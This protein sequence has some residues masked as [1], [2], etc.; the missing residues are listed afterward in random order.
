MGVAPVFGLQF[1]RQD[2]A[3][4]P[5]ISSNMD[6]VGLI[7]PCS[8]AN[9]NVFPLNTP[10]FV[11]SNDTATLKNLYDSNG[12]TDG[13]IVDALNGINSQLADLQIAAQVVIVV[14][15]YGSASDPN[16]KL[17]QT[18][19]NIM[20]SSVAGTG[21]WAFLKAPNTLYCTPRLIAAPG[22][23]GMMANSLDTL[24]SNVVG[25]GYQA[26]TLYTI[27]FGLG[28]GETNGAN[29][30]LPQAHAIS[31]SDGSINSSDLFIDSFGAWFT[32]APTAVLPAPDGPPIV[33]TF[34]S[35]Q[36]IFSQQPGIGSTIRLNGTTVTFVTT[37]PTGNQVQ[38][39]GN[40]GTTMSNLLTFLQGSNDTQILLCSYSLINATLTITD[41]TS[42][43][44]GNGFSL[45]STVNGISVSGSTLT[46]GQN[47]ASAV[48]ATLLC[49]IAL[50]ANPVVSA[51]SGG[52]LDGLMA[53][54]VVESAGTSMIA[55]ENWRDTIA[56]PRIIPLSGGVKVLN[57][58]GVIVVM[59]YAPR[60]IGSI[61][62]RDFATGYPFHSAA[63]QPI[64]GIVGPART[65]A[66]SLTDGSTEGQ[67]LLGA[68]IGILVRG[69]IGVETAISSGGFISIA[70][71]TAATDPLWQFYNVTRGR[72]FIELSLM[73][74]L[75]A[76]LGVSNIDRQTVTSVIGSIEAFLSQLTAL[77][78][79]LGYNV[80]FQGS[81][82]SAA[83]IRLGHLT[84]SFAAEEPPVLRRI[85]VMSARYA[86][87]ID[88]LV[89]QLATEL[90][91]QG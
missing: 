64:S 5:V 37:S 7:G 19:A 44:L 17:Q 30:V 77:Q 15:A 84:V 39:A 78:Q 56:S 41:K 4:L 66:F 85:T 82:N 63:N 46:G 14:T 53:H 11:F 2:D 38:I 75:R 83:E 91:F 1:I 10:V 28:S 48:Q 21:V 34:A 16:L 55:D 80:S 51:L 43:T 68:N 23:T 71:D 35:G 18:I 12:N 49:T 8:T 88:A 90:N 89:S 72:D 81:L 52:V 47:A 73:P 32:A 62:A 67:Q 20:G 57:S 65:I 3:S 87:A 13:Y 6:V 74:A 29:V 42:G 86:P 26:N 22:Y 76:Y 79:I 70:T 60:E 50:G 54:A 36:M 25:V 33:A 45:G 59:P 40:L 27:T 31:G 9:N 24:V 58:S 61:I 69:E